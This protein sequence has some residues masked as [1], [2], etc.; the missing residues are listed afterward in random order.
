MQER[1][2]VG[3]IQAPASGRSIGEPSRSGAGSVD[4][5]AIL[6]VI[7]LKRDRTSVQTGQRGTGMRRYRRFW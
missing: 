3:T 6:I 1:R 4:H 5:S 2:F 7:T